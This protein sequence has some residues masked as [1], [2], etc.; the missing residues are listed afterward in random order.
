MNLSY[1]DKHLSDQTEY[2]GLQKSKYWHIFQE[3]HPVLI[4]KVPRIRKHS[5]LEISIKGL[6]TFIFKTQ[7]YFQLE[8]EAGQTVT[9][10]FGNTCLPVRSI[11]VAWCCSPLKAMLFG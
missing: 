5:S 8:D 2:K 1:L 10:S 6:V 7:S 9:F 3:N 4:L 11:L